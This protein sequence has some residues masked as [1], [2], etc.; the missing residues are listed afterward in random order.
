MSDIYQNFLDN[1]FAKYSRSPNVLGVFEILASPLQDTSD[2]IDYILDHLSIGDAEGVIL[3]AKAGWIGVTRPL[4]QE[5][6]IFQLFSKY[7]LADDP[8]NRYGLA[9]SD[10]SSGGYLTSKTGCPSKSSPGA[11][12]GD[13]DFRLFIRAKAA[14]F[15]KLATPEVMYN[16]VLQFGIRAKITEGVRE[17]EIEPSSYRDMS[18]FIRYHI[19]H[20]GFLPAGIYT[21]IRSQ[22][23]PD[24][25]V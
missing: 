4:A 20:R 3:D 24:S 9:P 23:A 1:L 8:E 2:A 22:T 12:M 17:C 21:H 14:T 19:E 25:E 11:L 5:E 16:Y 15:R 10:L 7:E 13:D 18:M 6:N